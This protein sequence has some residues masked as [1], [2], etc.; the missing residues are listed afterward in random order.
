M[1]M[2]LQAAVEQPELGLAKQIQILALRPI[3]HWM[4]H[5]WAMKEDHRDVVMDKFQGN[6]KKINKT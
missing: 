2:C 5:I 6:G 3:L 4:L 1:R